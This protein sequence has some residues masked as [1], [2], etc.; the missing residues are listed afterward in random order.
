MSKKEDKIKQMI[1]ANFSEL[2]RRMKLY[3]SEHAGGGASMTDIQTALDELQLA[4]QGNDTTATLTAI[5]TIASAIPTATYTEAIASIK[6]VVDAL[7]KT[8]LTATD[9][10]DIIAAIQE[11]TPTID[12]TSVLNAIAAS[13]TA[14]KQA[15]PSIP[16][17]Y[18][19]QGAVAK[20]L[21]DIKVEIPS[22]IAREHEYDE[23]IAE[24][25]AATES[26]TA[27][28]SDIKAGKTALAMAINSKGVVSHDT[29]TLVDMATQISGITQETIEFEAGAE[30]EKQMFGTTTTTTPF[31]QNGP[32]WNLYKVMADIKNDGRFTKYG[33]ILLAEYYKGYDTIE[34]MNAGAGGGYL[35]SD[36]MYYTTDR[37]GEN[38]HVWNDAEDGMAN[39]WVAYLFALAETNYTIPSTELCPHSIHIGRSVGTISCAYEG[40][41]SEIVCTDGNSFFGTNFASTNPWSKNMIIRNMKNHNSTYGL[42]NHGNIASYVLLP[43]LVNL[44]GTL[45]FEDA[46]NDAMKAVVQLQSLKTIPNGSY[47]L[48]CRDLSD[49]R[50]YLDSIEEIKGYEDAYNVNKNGAICY[51]SY[52]PLSY[53]YIGYSDNDA[54]KAINIAWY[55]GGKDFSKLKDIEIKQGFRKPLNIMYGINLSREVLREHIIDRL[56]DNNGNPTIRISLNSVNLA[57]LTEEDIQVATDKNYTLA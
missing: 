11:A 29:D 15:M 8:T 39:R 17:D 4:L 3:V 24:I 35:T 5:K 47:I 45:I 21:D 25:K 51:S 16:T 7:P 34:L 49:I 43:D 19:R 26:L 41:I 23:R 20:T 50:L 9:K 14:I 1:K 46:N 32:L 38:A 6:Q 28:D 42:I 31:K 48:R 22:D 10:A 37:T 40:R 52:C 53:L 44:N 56:G 2:W 36:G 30:Y 57:A 27:L 54:S 13:E 33:G 18:A 55:R 12:F